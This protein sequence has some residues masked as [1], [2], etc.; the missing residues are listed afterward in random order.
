MTRPL[1]SIFCAVVLGAHSLTTLAADPKS[2]QT[3]HSEQ[4]ARVQ[5]EKKRDQISGVNKV[6]TPASHAASGFI[7]APVET[8]DAPA[9]VQKP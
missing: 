2:A 6:A 9:Q 1:L 7:D 5:I 3:L 8:G 4:E